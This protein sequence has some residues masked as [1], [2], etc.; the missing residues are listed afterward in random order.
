M[1]QTCCFTAPVVL[2]SDSRWKRLAPA[3]SHNTK[4]LLHR[5][6]SFEQWFK[7]SVTGSH[8]FAWCKVVVALYRYFWPVIQSAYDLLQLVRMNISCICTVSTVLSSGSK[9]RRVTTTCSRDTRLLLC[10]GDSFDQW[11]HVQATC[12][13]LFAW[14]KIVV[15]RNAPALVMPVDKSRKASGSLWTWFVMVFRCSGSCEGLHK[16][17]VTSDSLVYISVRTCASVN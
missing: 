14:Y 6:N 10:C 1:K 16:S 13:N 9:Y 17:R 15:S 8:L 2:A 12:S 3:C 5:S 11:L 7:V 4:L